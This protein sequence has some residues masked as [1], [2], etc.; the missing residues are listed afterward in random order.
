MASDL[1]LRAAAQGLG[2]ALGRACLASEDVANGILF[3]PFGSDRVRL[4][5]AYWLVHANDEPLRPAVHAVGEWIR[6]LA[7]KTAID[8]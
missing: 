4:P 2:V 1:V 6:S 5:D 7:R 8:E 3:R